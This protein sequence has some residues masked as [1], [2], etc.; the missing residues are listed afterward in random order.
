MNSANN[1]I[2]IPQAIY[3]D[4][5][6][7]FNLS[8]GVKNVDFIELRD[9]IKNVIGFYVPE[10]VVREWIQKRIEE[11]SEGIEK[12]DNI[13]RSLG[14]IMNRDPLNYEK[15][16]EF[17]KTIKGV[18]M[19]YIIAAGITLIATPNNIS[20]PTLI[21]MAIKKKAPFQ[22]K[23]E[24]GFRDAIALF[25]IIWHMQESK[26]SNAILLTNDKIFHHED[27]MSRFQTNELNI[28]IAPD[29]TSA[30]N[31]IET[32]I[33]VIVKA[34]LEEKKIKLMSFLMTRSEEIF[35]YVLKNARISE[36]FLKS[37]FKF[38]V[39]V[40]KILV[41][42]PK[43]IS[44]VSLGSTLTEG[45]Q[46]EG[47]ESVTFS[48]STEFDILVDFFFKP[49]LDTPKFSLSDPEDF[50][51]MKYQSTPSHVEQT[52]ITRDISVEAKVTIDENKYT[53]IKLLK[54][55]TY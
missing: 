8:H 24:K 36:R 15:P 53:N 23:R 46:P 1:K 42:R 37:D 27:V 28:N 34:Q 39:I 11:T 47:V 30:K 31:L 7:L 6:V 14:R 5:N 52:T 26:F 41:V 49:L 21:D 13:C 35:E 22:K 12:L 9:L 54:V 29:F 18:M 45:S 32:Q 25:T 19:K 20:L 4:T 44:N 17:E 50:E 16:R 10:V 40:K 43:K 2:V 48:V 3:F 51:K 38:P 55:I 33:D